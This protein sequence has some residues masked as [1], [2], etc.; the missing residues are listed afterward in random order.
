M[1]DLVCA[2]AVGAG[3]WL[4][5]ETA[6]TPGGRRPSSARWRRARDWLRQAGVEDGTPG[7]FLAL[8]LG[9]ALL[10]GLV[11]QLL[12]GWPVLDLIALALGGSAPLLVFRARRQRRRVILRAAL[13][14]ALG[15]VR[16]AVRSGRSVQEAL[17]SLGA[18]GPEPLRPEFRRL[19][20]DVAVRGFDAALLALRDR[21]ADPTLDLAVLALRLN[22]R[23]GSRQVTRVVDRLVQAAQS[24]QRAR[25][26][27]DAQQ[28][29]GRLAA[30]VVI[31]VPVLLL[32]SL[33][34]LNPI[35]AAA[36]DDAAGQVVLLAGAFVLLA[37]YLAMR[38]LLR[39]PEPPRLAHA[40]AAE[41]AA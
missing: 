23:L 21:L 12:L 28:A 9:A 14:D 6:T 13:V 30:H 26:E 4:L 19:E 32:L 8:S 2:L 35:Y 17:V 3:L 41:E 24:E 22:D 1:I 29:R 25:A 38:R 39:L 10:A 33:R 16:D 40:T 36:F 11:A 18:A 7:G 31:A 20:Q 15:Q 5:Y 37:G 34:L 27:L